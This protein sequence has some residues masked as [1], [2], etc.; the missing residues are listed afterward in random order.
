MKA[1]IYGAGS[2]GTVLGAYISK[3]GVDIDLITRNKDHVDAMNENGAHI[4]GTVDMVVPVHALTPDMVT[5]KYDL[6]ILMTKQLANKEILEGFKPHMTD[7]CIVCTMQNGLPELSVSEIVGEDRTMGCTVAWGATLHGHGVSEL[8]SETDSLSFGLGRMNGQKDDKLM[9]VKALLENMCPVEIEDN[10]MGVRWSKLLIN[11]AFSGMSAVMGGTFGDAAERRDSRVCC[12]NII[13]ECIDVA[14]AAGIKIEPVQGKDI[15]KL[16]Y[17]KGNGIKK[18]ISNFLIPIC[19]KKHRLL[20]A[21]MLQDLEKGRKCEIDAING[22]VCAYGDKYGVE[23][24][25]NDK[26]CEI[27]HGIEDGKYK[28]SFA[29][30][31]LF[32]ELSK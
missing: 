20:K 11:S 12:Q 27:V 29:N 1:C 4:I 2:L 32:S 6:V 18:K 13:K 19:I 30:V 21:S 23:T 10:F 8:T 14:N 26:V 28:Y 24:P 15:V 16:L 31:K 5:E 3:A 9:E 25:Y 22:V 7:D 17:Y